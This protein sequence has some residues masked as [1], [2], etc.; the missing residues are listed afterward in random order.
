MF[1][2]K[3]KNEN[4]TNFKVNDLLNFLRRPA[5]VIIVCAKVGNKYLHMKVILLKVKKKLIHPVLNLKTTN[6]LFLIVF[7]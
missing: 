2:F 5:I 1:V 6:Y 7:M 3:L 4:E